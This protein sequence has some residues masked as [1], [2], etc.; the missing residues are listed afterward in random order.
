MKKRRKT[1]DFNFSCKFR[2]YAHHGAKEI[3]KSTNFAN[4]H[5]IIKP[6]EKNDDELRNICVRA[7][8]STRRKTEKKTQSAWP[9]RYRARG[10]RYYTVDKKIGR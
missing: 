4:N 5:P 9:I 2:H 10:I 3:D 8:I 6:I 1:N 7:K